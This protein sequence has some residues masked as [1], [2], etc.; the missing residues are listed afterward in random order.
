MKSIQ[1]LKTSIVQKIN[2]QDL[3][4]TIPEIL[5]YAERTKN[6]VLKKRCIN[7]LYGYSEEEELPDYRKI[8]VTFYNKSQKEIR[9]YPQGSI[10]TANQIFHKKRFH[11]KGP[12]EKFERL[13]IE[14]G[15]TS[16]IALRE[17]FEVEVN[18]QIQEAHSFQYFASDVKPS[19]L[20]LK[21]ILLKEVDKELP[22][23]KEDTDDEIN[24]LHHTVV[25]LSSQLF[26]NK[27]YRQA[28]L[29]ATIEL[30]NQVKQKSGIE[31]LDNTPL[32]QKS[33]SQNNPIIKL[34]NDKDLQLGFMWLFS[35]AVMTLRNVNAHKLNPNMTK[36]E[37]I[38]QLYFLSYLF[39]V[40]DQAT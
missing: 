3:R 1:E 15:I 30:V 21:Q 7:E 31:T 14:T 33:F 20:K 36:Q 19:I 39:R 35:G 18:G 28:V 37:C 22:V 4:I 24:S 17:P 11:H 9:L 34:S 5:E 2:I 29:D 26:R 27:H 8:P 40:L 13:A 16:I 6:N 25:K 23:Y 38:E 32:I 10:I 12:I